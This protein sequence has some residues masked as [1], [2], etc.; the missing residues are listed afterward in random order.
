MEVKAICKMLSKGTS[1]AFQTWREETLTNKVHTKFLRTASNGAN[2]KDLSS[3]FVSWHELVVLQRGLRA[4]YCAVLRRVCRRAI[5]TSFHTWGNE[6]HRRYVS[7][8]IIKRLTSRSIT[9]AWNSWVAFHKYLMYRRRVRGLVAAKALAGMFGSSFEAWRQHTR[10][11]REEA[12][13]QERLLLRVNFRQKRAALHIW[14]AH[15]IASG[16]EAKSR[17]IEKVV[18]A[19][20]LR[21]LIDDRRLTHAAFECWA[22]MLVR[23]TNLRRVATADAHFVRRK[24]RGLVAVVAALRTAWTAAAA[25]LNRA[26]Q[27]FFLRLGFAALRENAGL[28]LAEADYVVGVYVSSEAAAAVARAFNGWHAIAVA[29]TSQRTAALAT[30]ERSLWQR[31]CRGALALLQ[32][33][34][35]DA[36]ERLGE[37]ARSADAKL[38]HRTLLDLHQ[39]SCEGLA[40]N[41][42]EMVSR[43]RRQNMLWVLLRWR[44]VASRQ[45]RLVAAFQDLERRCALAV[46]ATV[47]RA[48][49]EV[50]LLRHRRGA[51]LHGIA[52]HVTARW[53]RRVLGAW[54]ISFL[55]R[56][57]A[58]AVPPPPPGPQTCPAVTFG[59]LTPES[60]LTQGVLRLRGCNAAR[61]A[62]AVFRAWARE[63]VCRAAR[64][65]AAARASRNVRRKLAARV[66][67]GWTAWR[68]LFA[69]WARLGERSSRRLLRAAL[70]G[71]GE[72]VRMRARF[73]RY[74][75]PP[76]PFPRTNRTSLVLPLVLSGHAASLTPY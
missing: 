63:C 31:K 42:T 24:F 10:R 49:R 67:H 54:R 53:R 48:W 73:A 20:E 7:S 6:I 51:G 57:A 38:L 30:S 16:A 32:D 56:R 76:L 17:G 45:A 52:S 14:R 47:V 62:G 50:A 3:N 61:R 66:L 69:Q 9:R 40:L 4:A 5:H 29:A 55:V 22:S 19:M 64:R 70:H 43:L 65:A 72:G 11:E 8:R 58:A 28:S 12:R 36:R 26:G 35:M 46:R 25:A 33:A 39:A 18:R 15:A 23:L 60:G 34:A 71:W 41:V 68:R 59:R 2:R 21:G 74:H 13:K 75:S 44:R 37:A 27:N 1:S